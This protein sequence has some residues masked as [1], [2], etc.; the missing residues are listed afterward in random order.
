MTS[1][2]RKMTE[3]IRRR[4]AELWNQGI[5]SSSI[6]AEVG[7]TRNAVIGAVYRLRQRGEIM[8]TAEEKRPR[9]VRPKKILATIKNMRKPHELGKPVGLM[10]LTSQ[11][12]RFIVV[13]GSVEETRYCNNPIDRSSY[14]SEHYRIC[15]VP[16]RRAIEE[17]QLRD[18]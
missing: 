1:Q 9:K 16:P 13:E 15:Y 6:A 11:S 12:C 2:K 10:K 4:I 5:S 7:L 17:S 18:K 14:C 8:K 3:E